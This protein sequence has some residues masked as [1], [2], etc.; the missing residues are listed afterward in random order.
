[1][2]QGL[3]KLPPELRNM[4]YT[5]VFDDQLLEVT[6]VDRQMRLV[7]AT[8][9]HPFGLSSTCRLLYR[10]TKDLPRPKTAYRIVTYRF[11][12]LW[13]TCSCAIFANANRFYALL[14]SIPAP[15]NNRF[16]VV[17][18]LFG[19]DEVEI[20]WPNKVLGFT[21]GLMSS[22]AKLE[23]AIHKIYPDAKVTFRTVRNITQL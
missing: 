20:M 6:K 23:R 18:I 14:R 13:D 4:I 11:A 22:E 1:M 9:A 15:Y 5:Y 16:D 21:G 7:G 12:S 2:G 3:L 19:H 10:E 17:G 8:N